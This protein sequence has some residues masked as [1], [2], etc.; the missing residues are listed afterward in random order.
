M[1]TVIN[2]G[3]EHFAAG[4]VRNRV[5]ADQ[6]GVR[7]LRAGPGAHVRDPGGADLGDHDGCLGLLGARADLR[8]RLAVLG[9]H[10]PLQVDLLRLVAAT[11]LQLLMKGPDGA[12]MRHPVK[13]G[14]L[15]FV[16][17]KVAHVLTNEGTK[18]GVIVE[19]ELK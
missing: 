4:A 9:R 18:A 15:H 1:G 2:D 8:R 13:A 7:V 16:D 11:P 19:V 3:P 14:D 5:V 12:A 10:Q 17:A 6:R